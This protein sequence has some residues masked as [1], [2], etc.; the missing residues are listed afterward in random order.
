MLALTI[1]VVGRFIIPLG[2]LVILI[3]SIVMDKQKIKSNKEFIEISKL[4]ILDNKK[5]IKSN[6]EHKAAV[7]RLPKK[8][9]EMKE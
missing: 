4:I 9:E 3:I 2:L 8:M 7:E 6:R 1:E 5:R